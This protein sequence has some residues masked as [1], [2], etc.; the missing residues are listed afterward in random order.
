MNYLDLDTEQRK[1]VR[2][3]TGYS[4]KQM[5]D[6]NPYFIED[7]EFADEMV[8]QFKDTYGLPDEATIYLDK[9]HLAR[10]WGMD[11]TEVTIDGKDYQFR[12]W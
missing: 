8:E 12:A 1:E 9:E 11:Y 4:D 2:K 6:E 10:E 5:R 7:Y 3:Q